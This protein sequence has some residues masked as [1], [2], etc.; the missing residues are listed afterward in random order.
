MLLLFLLKLASCT[1]IVTTNFPP[2]EPIPTINSI[3][4]QGE[5]LSI[6]VSLTGRLDSIVL[7]NV[8]NASVDLY[9]DN[10]F[11]E[12]LEYREDGIYTSKTIVESEKDY[13][14]KA[15]IPN[16]DTIICHQK[17]PHPN[18]ILDVQYISPAGIDENGDSYSSTKVTFK[19]DPNEQKYNEIKIVSTQ[20]NNSQN[21]P[22]RLLVNIIS[23]MSV[24]TDPVLLNEGLA[25]ALFSN[26]IIKDSIYTITLNFPGG[27]S[28]LYS[29][30]VEL[31]S[32]TYDYYRYHK[33]YYLYN[34]GKY[35]DIIAK[36]TEFPLYSNIENAYGI[37]AGYSVFVSDTIRPVPYED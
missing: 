22:K 28:N 11:I 5:P 1:E 23:T 21:I 19:N 12:R 15:I 34:E 7:P 29:F 36:A 10:V 4:V 27:S 18:S 26:E 33:Q 16:Y 31:R 6:N 35:G 14:I 2:F 8:A 17:L 25:I 3:L 32:V 13:Q 37:F 9:I 24:I 30:L 20:K